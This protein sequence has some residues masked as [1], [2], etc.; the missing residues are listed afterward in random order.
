MKTA[1]VRVLLISACQFFSFSAFSLHAQDQTVDGTLLLSHVGTPQSG[2]H[3][4]QIYSDSSSI[5]HLYSYDAGGIAFHASGGGATPQTDMFIMPSG[6]VGIG[7]TSPSTK[8]QVKA[9]GETYFGFGDSVGS[10]V[11]GASGTNGYLAIDTSTSGRDSGVRLG[12]GGT[13]AWTLYQDGTNNRF[14]IYSHI[15]NA[16]VLTANSVG[17]VG[18]GTATPA[19]KLDVAGDIRNSFGPVAMALGDWKTLTVG[20]APDQFYPV[21]I[22]TSGFR[23]DFVEIMQPSVHEDGMWYGSMHFIAQFNNNGWGNVV[24]VNRLL[25]NTNTGSNSYIA[26]FADAAWGMIPV[27]WLRGDQSYQYRVTNEGS[28]SVVGYSANIAI[29]GNAGD[30]YVRYVSPI[31]VPDGTVP[32]ISAS[33]IAGDLNVVGNLTTSGTFS[34]SNYNVTSGAVNGGS[35]GLSL[36]AGGSNQNISITPSGSGHTLISGSVGIGSTGGTPDA[37]PRVITSVPLDIYGPD[38]N[39]STTTS[40][41]PVLRLNRDVIGGGGY[42]KHSAADF[43]LSRWADSDNYPYTR[44]DL[45]LSGAPNDYSDPSIDVMSLRSDGN[46]GIGTTAP[47]AKLEIKAGFEGQTGPKEALRIWGPN[48]PA[49]TNSAQDLKWAFASAGSA[50]IRSFRGGNWD[51]YLQFLTNPVAGPGDSPLVRMHIAENGN[52]GIGTTTPGGKLTISSDLPTPGSYV[53]AATGAY[54]MFE[55]GVPN[56]VDNKAFI[57]LHRGGSVAYQLG[58][59]GNDFILAQTGGAANDNLGTERLRVSANGNVG[60]GTSTPGRKLDVYG[61]LPAGAYNVAAIGASGAARDIFIAGQEGVSNGFTVQ[62]TGSAMR[63]AFNDGSVGIGIAVPTRRLDVYGTGGWNG[64]SGIRLQGNNP[65][66]EITDI[67]SSQRWLIANGVISGSDGKLGLAYDITRGRHN[68]V[69]DTAGHVGISTNSPSATLEVNGTAQIDGQFTALAGSQLNGQTNMQSAAIAGTS[70]FGGPMTFVSGGAN[71]AAGSMSWGTTATDPLSLVAGTNRSLLLASGG[72]ASAATGMTVASTGYVGIGTGAPK[73]KLHIV[74]G[75]SGAN[76]YETTG[77]FTVES[78]GRAII[79]LLTPAN[80]DAYLM[81]GNPDAANRAFIGYTGSGTSTPDQMVLRTSGS[82]QLTG[83]N[84]GI[85]TSAAPSAKLEVAGDTKVTSPSAST[86][87]ATGALVVTGGAGIGGNENVGGTLT[88][89][90]GAT[91]TTIS[92]SGI[93]TGGSVTAASYVSTTGSVAGSSSGNGLTLSAGAVNQNV[94]LVAAGAGNVVAQGN[95]VGQGTMTSQG[96]LTANSDLLVNGKVGVGVPSGGTPTTKMDVRGG[97]LMLS[98]A[99]IGSWYGWT[100]L[101]DPTAPALWVQNQGT[102][103]RSELSTAAATGMRAV[104]SGAVTGGTLTSPAPTPAGANLQLRFAAYD[105][106]NFYNAATIELTADETHSAS[107]HATSI[108]FG[109]YGNSEVMRVTSDG[110]VGIGTTNPANYKLAVAGPISAQGQLNV[111]G[112]V[113]AKEVVVDTTL[114][115]PDYVFDANYRNMPLS[116]VEQHIKAEKHLPGVPSAQEVAEHGVNVGQM[117]TV[118]LQKIEELTLHMIEQEKAMHELRADN[119]QLRQEVAQL[120]AAVK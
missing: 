64:D 31:S 89:G 35:T 115:Q 71:P 21:R 114:P 108:R 9:N 103:V 15:L 112:V 60:I 72:A 109:T 29:Y 7:T 8:L 95:F 78:G 116:E 47:N 67:G 3:S 25:L 51:T 70:S 90:T 59:S 39:P 27:V 44:L 76:P 34:A 98:P 20:G 68:I 52:V 55:V 12:H 119:A 49:N 46:V 113:Y 106:T 37:I 1:R 85:G 40:S 118:L 24:S 91:A 101:F 83:G 94:T 42:R 48:G 43:M 93:T 58:I 87:S 53:Q 18:I 74:Q 117:Q 16:P 30:Q 96:R 41:A 13:N 105:G 6:R 19:A 110:K 54:G 81:F 5:L 88:V 28:L 17:N 61:N 4:D 120:Q 69:V 104:Y 10:F 63:Y 111:D 97:G 36:T 11:Q 45:R 66:I 107:T 26:R 82:F 38:I 22:P 100:G 65:G 75:P 57:S 102:N 62:Y 50:G 84:V 2:I 73:T 99:G 32:S 77:G 14:N 56:S 79:Q 80:Q 33:D 86:S 23:R 92:T